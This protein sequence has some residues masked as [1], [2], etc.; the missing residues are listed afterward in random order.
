MGKPAIKPV[1]HDS[2]LPVSQ[3]PTEME[4]TFSV[5]KR[6]STGIENEK[7][8]IELDPSFQHE[9]ASL[10]INQKRLNDPVRDLYIS[11]KKAEVLGSRLQQWNLLEPG[12]TI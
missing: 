11:K 8:R 12:T 6:A 4:D 10:F 5:D 9:S 1:S 7:N 3:P 2:D